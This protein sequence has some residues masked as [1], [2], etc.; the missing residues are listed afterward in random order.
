ME[1]QRARM[2]AR[3]ARRKLAKLQAQKDSKRLTGGTKPKTGK[4]ATKTLEKF[5][6]NNSK[7]SNSKSNKH[8]SKANS[9]VRS[10][11]SD[12]TPPKTSKTSPSKADKQRLTGGSKPKTGQSALK[13]LSNFGNKSPKEGDTKTMNGNKYVYRRGSWQR[14]KPNGYTYG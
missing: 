10:L 2:E 11:R 13:T 6:S 4:D 8:K 9:S 1:Q 7:S 12:P 5:N 14:V 3:R